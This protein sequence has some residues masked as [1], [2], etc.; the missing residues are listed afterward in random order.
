[1]ILKRDISKKQLREFAILIGLGFPILI[2]WFLPMISGHYFRTWTLLIGI[3]FL[4]IGCINP[5]LL[6][7]PF[8]LW[9]KI[10]NILGWINSHLILGFVF[11]I[12]LQPIALIM[13]ILNYDPLRI[14]KGKINSYKENAEKK[15]YDFKRIF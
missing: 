3:P 13:K 7:Y 10:G 15:I 9:M 2:G 12:I 6:F 4:I 8:K 14:K 1:M 11:I 5:R